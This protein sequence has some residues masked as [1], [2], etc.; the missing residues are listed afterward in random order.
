MITNL[1]ASMITF[2]VTNIT[3]YPY[4]PVAARSLPPEQSMAI[5]HYPRAGND[6]WIKEETISITTIIL[7]LH[8]VDH[9]FTVTNGVS[10]LVTHMKRKELWET[11]KD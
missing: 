11:V 7:C 4:D 9:T 3:E 2:M 10:V 6:K 5:R 1:V 8:E